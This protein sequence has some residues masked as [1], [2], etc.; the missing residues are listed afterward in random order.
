MTADHEL[1]PQVRRAAEALRRPVTP[2]PG[3]DTRLMAA[4]RAEAGGGP[5][6]WLL[7]PR[8][9]RVAPL[10]AVAGALALA[11]L[12][13]AGTW[14]V[15]RPGPA[16]TVATR[17]PVEPAAAVQPVR[18]VLAAPGARTVALVG[19]FND[20]DPTA[21]PL[22]AEAT[23]GVWVVEVPLQA[24]RHEYAFVVDGERWLADPSAPTVGDDFGTPNSVV[25]VA[26][27]S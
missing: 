12:A 20:W 19:S 27:R 26:G 25:T 22:R 15:M 13:V 6:D 23:A 24:G 17:P 9:I 4:V 14:A 18:F 21:T 11:S 3:F 16:A 7:R 2:G 10:A 1:D 5:I 8:A